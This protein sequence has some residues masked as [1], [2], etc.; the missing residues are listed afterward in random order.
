[1]TARPSTVETAQRL[2]AAA[3]AID[4]GRTDLPFA[5]AEVLSRHLRSTARYGTPRAMSP[6]ESI[7]LAVLEVARDAT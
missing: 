6:L 1:M 2:L 3:D 5:L 4:D 7:A